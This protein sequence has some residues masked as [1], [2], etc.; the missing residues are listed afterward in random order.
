MSI[1]TNTINTTTAAELDAQLMSASEDGDTEL[2][3][4]L[5]A[6]GADP[7][8]WANMPLGSASFNGHA[9][10]VKLLLDAGADVHAMDD[11]MDEVDD[12]EVVRVLTDWKEA[13][14]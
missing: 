9:K 10:V 5:L 11:L 1:S 7:A 4:G 3:R 12:D 6:A 8:T 14:K 13:N 2:V